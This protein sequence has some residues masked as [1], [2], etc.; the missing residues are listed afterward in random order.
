MV[1][2]KGE[3]GRLLRAQPSAKPGM[4][5]LLIEDEHGQQWLFQGCYPVSQHFELEDPDGVVTMETVPVEVA[6]V[7]PF[8]Y[9]DDGK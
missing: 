7:D 3:K 2:E 5:D 4:V 1:M 9:P 6:R 8:S